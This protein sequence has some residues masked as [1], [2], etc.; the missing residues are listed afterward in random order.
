MMIAFPQTTAAPFANDEYGE[1][2][3]NVF[4]FTPS[5]QSKHHIKTNTDVYLIIYYVYKYF[6]TIDTEISLY[7]IPASLIPPRFIGN[8]ISGKEM[9]TNFII[10]QTIVNFVFTNIFVYMC[11]DLPII[12]N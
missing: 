7:T 4:Q 3:V 6:I 8:N 11:F 9:L 10:F 2:L 5:Y 12:I 1:L